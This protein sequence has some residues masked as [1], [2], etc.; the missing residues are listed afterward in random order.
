MPLRYLFPRGRREDALRCVR[1]PP[2]MVRVFQEATGVNGMVF[3]HIAVKKKAMACIAEFGKGN[4]EAPLEKFPGNRITSYNVCY[5]KLLRRRRR[6]C[7][8]RP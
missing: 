4:F 5:T 1:R 3:G 6:G 7:T 8:G 2:D